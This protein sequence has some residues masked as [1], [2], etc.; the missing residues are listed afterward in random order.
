M[1]F[2]SLRVFCTKLPHVTEDVKWGNDLCFLICGKMF[3]V[4]CLDAAVTQRLSFKCTPEIFAELIEVD[5]IIP[6]PY[7]ARNNWVSMLRFDVLRDAEIEKL[8]RDS[9]ELVLAKLPKNLHPA[10]KA[11][12]VRKLVSNKSVVTPKKVVRK[13]RIRSER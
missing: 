11:D 9:Y 13:K 10:L 4:T 7:M 2:D 6:A 12:S 1:N 5:G 8:L 3:A